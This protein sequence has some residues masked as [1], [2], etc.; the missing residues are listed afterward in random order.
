MSC[1]VMVITD[2]RS[3]CLAKTVESL[4]ATWPAG[5]H[6]DRKIMVVD[7]PSRDFHAEMAAA[8]PDFHVVGS[9]RKLGFHGAIQ[10][11][12][13]NLG[14]SQWIFHLEDDF[15]LS[16][17]GTLPIEGMQAVIRNSSFAQVALKRQAWAEA[18][19]HAGGIVEQWPDLYED[20]NVLG[21][22]VT[23][24]KQFFTTNPSLYYMN[25]PRHGWPQCEG[26]EAEFTKRLLKENYEF[27]YWG[28]KFDPPRVTHIGNSRIGT[29]Y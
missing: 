16:P 4:R 7:K 26:S 19:K 23:V 10:L 8:Y 2:G 17:C 14:D 28:K 12:W 15:D 20:R 3:A 25:I 9:N 6:I 18:E 5:V 27:A 29:G 1:A 24:H 21:Y 13:E 11:G 22:D